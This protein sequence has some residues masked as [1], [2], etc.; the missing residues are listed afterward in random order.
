MPHIHRSARHRGLAKHV[1][2]TCHTYADPM[3]T[4]CQSHADLQTIAPWPTPC[5]NHAAF[6]PNLCRSA[7][8]PTPQF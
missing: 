4:P 8:K 7:A 6:M 2:N 1:P 3:L 5:R